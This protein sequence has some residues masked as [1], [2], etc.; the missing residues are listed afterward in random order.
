MRG[1]KGR[2]NLASICNV[3]PYEEAFDC[4]DNLDWYRIRDAELFDMEDLLN[5]EDDFVFD[6]QEKLEYFVS[7]W[8]EAG[9]T[10]YKR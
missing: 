8:D 10:D 6:P 7:L 2:G 5:D 1:P 9:I 4:Y 3:T